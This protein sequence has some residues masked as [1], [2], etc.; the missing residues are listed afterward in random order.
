MRSESVEQLDR[1][2]ETRILSIE[3]ERKEDEQETGPPP[4]SLYAHP[5]V[6]G[7]SSLFVPLFHSASHAFEPATPLSEPRL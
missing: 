1:R 6:F 4:S 5:V 2:A 3:K 7:A